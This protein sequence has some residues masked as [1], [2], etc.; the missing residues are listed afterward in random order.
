MGRLDSVAAAAVRVGAS[1]GGTLTLER[2]TGTYYDTATGAYLPSRESYS[3]RCVIGQFRD[4][5]FEGEVVKPGDRRLVIE[6]ASV[7][8]AEGER[9]EVRPKDR[10]LGMAGGEAVIQVLRPVYAGD[11]STVPAAYIALARA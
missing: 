4:E 8:D 10:I 1:F 9:V 11:A 6:A 2:V 7:K 5:V 3:M